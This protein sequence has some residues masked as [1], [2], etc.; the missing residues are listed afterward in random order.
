MSRIELDGMFVTGFEDEA[1]TQDLHDRGKAVR[2]EDARRSAAPVQPGD[3]QGRRYDVADES[4]LAFERLPVGRDDIVT[5][6]LLGVAAAVQTEFA[7]IRH[8]QI[9]RNGLGRVDTS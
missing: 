8:V 3:T 1:V 7:A 2:A 5:Q 9:D 4:D 6:R